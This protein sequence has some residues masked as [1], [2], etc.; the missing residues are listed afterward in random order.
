MKKKIKKNKQRCQN[1]YKTV[2]V[3]FKKRIRF[4]KTI[5]FLKILNNFINTNYK[6]HIHLIYLIY[7]SFCKLI[8]NFFTIK[9][10]SSKLILFFF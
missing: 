1:S 8:I 5:L 10:K 2:I 7:I 9:K 3:N 4:L 6:I